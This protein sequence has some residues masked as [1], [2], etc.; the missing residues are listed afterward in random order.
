MKKQSIGYLDVDAAVCVGA[1]E[2]AH[3]QVRLAQ[4][5]AVLHAPGTG[6]RNKG[7]RATAKKS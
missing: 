7:A 3:A 6:V 5:A 2:A 1:G 4:G